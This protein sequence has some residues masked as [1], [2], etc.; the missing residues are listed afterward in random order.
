MQY[1]APRPLTFRLDALAL[2]C[3]ACG[4]R[5]SGPRDDASPKKV[6]KALMQAAKDQRRKVRVVL[7]GCL[8]LCP[9]RATA[10]VVAG[11]EGS[12]AQFAIE[13]LAQAPAAL[14]GRQAGADRD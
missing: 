6:A 10:V 4:K 13:T 14:P 5:S 9:K 11:K 2:V 8:G 1:D 3:K 12:P 7:T